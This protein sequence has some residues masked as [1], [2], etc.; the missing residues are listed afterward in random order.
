VVLTSVDEGIRKPDVRI[1]HRALARLEVPVAAAAMIGNQL[2]TDIAGALAVGMPAIL[3]RWNDA[4]PARYADVTPTA[5]VRTWAEI[6]AVL[7][8]LEGTDRS[9]REGKP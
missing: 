4:Y 2:D 5:L 3:L 7:E 8:R 6:P 9:T 1:F